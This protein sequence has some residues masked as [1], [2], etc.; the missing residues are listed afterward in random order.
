MQH[1]DNLLGF[2]LNMDI[3]FSDREKNRLG[4]HMEF[5]LF[6][7]KN[8][9]YFKRTALKPHPGFLAQKSEGKKTKPKNP[10]EIK[11]FL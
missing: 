6:W 5:C 11:S 10:P 4:C 1:H 2:Y 8:S 7:P 3:H 9:T